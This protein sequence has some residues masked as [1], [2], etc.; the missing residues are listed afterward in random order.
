MLPEDIV[1]SLSHWLSGMNDVEKIAALNS[2][3]RFI[4]Y[5]GPFRDE[6]IGCVQWVP[7]ECVTANDYNPEAISLVEQK[8]LELSLVQDGFTQPVVVTVGRTE[9]LHYH[10]MDGFQHYF[11]SQK[12]I[13][14]KRLRG[15]IP[16]TIIR[17]RQDAIFS[18]IAATTREQEALKTK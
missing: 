10:V 5:H 18:L 1:H 17:P 4:H 14:R 11:I 2:L 15:H 12:P 3:Q 6:P 16:V 9:D 13:L 8:I 7:T